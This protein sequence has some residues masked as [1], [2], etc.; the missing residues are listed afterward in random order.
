M[1]AERIGDTDLQEP[2]SL[3]SALIIGL[4]VST[5]HPLGM[6]AAAAMP[7][8]CLC[9]LNTQGRIQKR[10]GLLQ[11]RPMANNSGLGSV[12][13]I[14]DASDTSCAL[15]RYCDPAVAAVDDGV[16]FASSALLMASASRVTGNNPSAS[17]SCRTC[18]A[19][20]RSRL[21]ISGGGL[22]RVDDRRTPPRNRSFYRGAGPAPPRACYLSHW[23]FRCRTRQRWLVPT[24]RRCRASSR[25][26]CGQ[27]PFW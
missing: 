22:G 24:F 2:L 12:L 27:Y 4:G 15:D 26:G 25:L 13:E 19:S 1:N 7:L 6:V 23:L 9:P 16:D 20:H 8:A 10:I 11:C 5:G 3:Y 21:S 17:R 14:R 18:F